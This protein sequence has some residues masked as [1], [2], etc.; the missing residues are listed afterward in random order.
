MANGLK[1]AVLGSNGTLGKIFVR[2][3]NHYNIV[4]V[5]RS[6]CDLKDPVAVKALLTRENFDAIILCA[7]N[8]GKQSLGDFNI[9]QFVENLIIFNNLK[10]LSEYYG[11]L[12]NIGSGAEFDLS[13]PISNALEIE[14]FDKFPRDGYGLAK[15]IISRQIKEMDNAITLR[16][17]GCFD[18]SEPDYRL[19]RKFA[20]T[21]YRDGRFMLHHDRKFSW[22]SAIDLANIIDQTII[23]WKQFPKD[24]NCSYDPM[25]IS[26]LLDTWCSI[27]RIDPRTYEIVNS[28]G[29][30]YTC[31]TELMKEFFSIQYGLHKSLEQYI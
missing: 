15:N 11:V 17:F 9:N 22:I 20:D 6:V 19:L 24:I 23:N 21:V 14:I 3:L 26:R 12:I 8:G 16:V 10:E 29:L 18:P 7:T 28:T 4:G 25:P 31:N 1:V 13:W 5:N 2:E 30:E 27:H